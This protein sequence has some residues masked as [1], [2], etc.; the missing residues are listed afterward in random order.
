MKIALLIT[1][2]LVVFL[3]LG[4]AAFSQEAGQENDKNKD[5]PT[6]TWEQLARQ[7]GLMGLPARPRDQF[8]VDAF[9]SKPNQVFRVKAEIKLT[10][11]EWAHF[12]Q[13][14]SKMDFLSSWSYG[15]VVPGV[16]DLS[17]RDIFPHGTVD[18]SKI[19]AQ[20][21]HITLENEAGEESRL[22]VLAPDKDGKTG[23][24][25]YFYITLRLRD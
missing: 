14:E 4:S 10:A 22:Y 6:L 25:F 20:N 9:F 3:G 17:M 21:H 2:L 13:G 16:R 1:P 19:P 5:R 8:K 7:A 15:E 18:S 23:S 11:R 24:L 12:T